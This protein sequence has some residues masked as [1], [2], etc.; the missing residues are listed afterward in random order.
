MRHET[1]ISRCHQFRRCDGRYIRVLISAQEVGLCKSYHM[2]EL[3][4]ETDQLFLRRADLF[5]D[6]ILRILAGADTQNNAHCPK[7]MLSSS[8]FILGRSQHSF[9]YDAHA[10]LCD[11][12]SGACSYS[13]L[14]GPTG[15]SQFSHRGLNSIRSNPQVP[16]LN[17][18]TQIHFVVPDPKNYPCL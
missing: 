1:C 18:C 14:C 11:R 15:S 9:R 17:L 13:R 5:V 10:G 8:C 16:N 6:L 12:R 2:L 4:N 3:K 7:L